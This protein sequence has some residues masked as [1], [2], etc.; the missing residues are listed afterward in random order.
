[1]L[2]VATERREAHLVLEGDPVDLAALTVPD[3]AA[4]RA[5]LDVARRYYTPALL[6]HCLRSYF[7][8]AAVGQR[9]GRVIDQEL[10]YVAA[11]LHDVGLTEPFDSYAL[12]F[13]EA[14][15][16][17]AR[18]FAAAA[19]WR[20][21]RC[22]RVHEVIVRHMGD[23]VDPEEDPEGHLLEVATAFDIGGRDQQLW[24]DS[25]LISLGTA[26]PRLDLAAEFADRFA[27]Q[28]LRK[29]GSAA[30]Q[31]SRSGIRSRLAAHPLLALDG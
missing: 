7:L 27:D 8:A 15:G 29:P 4:A 22:Q 28:E 1:L 5:S 23:E 30:A 25:F 19:G 9:G 26:Y 17:V 20:P 11:M 21:E 16:H 31:A 12:P 13:E 6:N 18:V 24:E 3:S 14:G 10:L 2:Q